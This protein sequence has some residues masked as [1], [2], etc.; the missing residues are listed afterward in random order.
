MFKA[1]WNFE[2][3]VKSA[4]ND[5]NLFLTPNLIPADNMIDA[6]KMADTA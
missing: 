2:N 6:P 3:A 4:K 1:Q 5:P